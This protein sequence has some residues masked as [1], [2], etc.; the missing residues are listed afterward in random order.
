M[1]KKCR[2]VTLL[3]TIHPFVI[4]SFVTCSLALK[5]VTCSTLPTNQTVE[6]IDVCLSSCTHNAMICLP[7]HGPN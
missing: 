7:C 1:L 6:D 5:D 2:Y 3:S 4:L